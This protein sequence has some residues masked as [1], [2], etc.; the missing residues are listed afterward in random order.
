MMDILGSYLFGIILIASGVLLGRLMNV[1]LILLGRHTTATFVG[2]SW[3]DPMD[4][5]NAY[6]QASEAGEV[7][8]S[9]LMDAYLDAAQNMNGPNPPMR[10][11]LRQTISFTD[12]R[13]QT[14]EVPISSGI[15]A[16]TYQPG[17]SI[18]IVHSRSNPSKTLVARGKNILFSLLLPLVLILGGM[19]LIVITSL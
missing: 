6:K 2:E 18:R 3:E 16:G 12:A 19:A 10:K 11:Y 5:L 8:P 15:P 14:H 13:G 4:A 17:Q 1:W 9:P 7:P